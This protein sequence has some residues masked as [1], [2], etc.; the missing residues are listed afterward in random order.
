M[1]NDKNKVLDKEDLSTK[2]IKNNI[3]NLKKNEIIKGDKDCFNIESKKNGDLNI[4]NNGI[5]DKNQ[6]IKEPS[7]IDENNITFN[8]EINDKNIIPV[9]NFFNCNE[10]YF[11]ENLLRENNF[12]LKSKNYIEKNSFNNNTKIEDI[13]RNKINNIL[14]DINLLQ[15]NLNYN[16][17]S[18]LDEDLNFNRNKEL[19]LNKP[20]NLYIN[21]FEFGCK[22]IFLIFL[23]ILAKNNFF[24]DYQNLEKNINK[25]L[26]KEN[27][28][29]DEEKAQQ[30]NDLKPK[31]K[32]ILRTG[33]WYC[34]YCNNLNFSFRKEC[35]IC[36]LSKFY[37]C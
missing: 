1:L 22:Y 9:I 34:G 19:D 29:G 20:L 12:T 11:K 31:K 10:T 21:N 8:K 14:R 32:L 28:E 4:S 24:L 18:K 17:N 15:N 33:D 7:F 13:E 30:F 16:N 36:R 23:F 6:I 27:K 26:I 37:W 5:S 3:Y 2:K 25:Q 35:N